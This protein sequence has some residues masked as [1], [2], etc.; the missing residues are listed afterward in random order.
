MYH[1]IRKQNKNLPYLNYLNFKNFEKQILYFKRKYQFFDCND[2]S[3]FSGS[4]N[5]KNKIFLTFDDGLSCHYKY[6]FR[7]LKKHNLNG[8]FYIPTQPLIKN[9]LLLP[10][11]IHLILGK[12]GGKKS[13][14]TL[15]KFIDDKMLDKKK[16]KKFRQAT[17]LNQKNIKYVNFFKRTINYYLKKK[18]K[19]QIIDKIFMNLFGKNEN[20]I[21]KKFYLNEKEIKKMTKEGMVIGSHSVTHPLMSEMSNS[22]ISKEIDLSFDYLS[23]FYTQK[24]YCHPY[25]GFKSFNDYT[26]N[27]LNKKKVIFSMNV[28]SKDISNYQILNRP[29]ALPRYDCNFFPYGKIDRIEND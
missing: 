22:E 9:K 6:A 5:I 1:Y 24:T 14:Q 17:Y 2:F 29:Q 20:K 21:S 8:I 12:F 25:G 28:Y 3:F 18:Y 27:Y 23:Q 26:E 10:H 19:F 16:V 4:E 15:M 7:I 11:K 13:F